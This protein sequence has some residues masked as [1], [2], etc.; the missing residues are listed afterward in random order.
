MRVSNAIAIVLLFLTGYA[1]GR[2]SGAP[3]V[4]DRPR[5]GRAWE[6]AGGDHDGAG[7]I[8]T[9]RSAFALMHCGSWGSAP[10]TPRGQ[11]TDAL[12]A[13]ADQLRCRRPS[14]TKRRASLV[15]L[16][17]GLHLHRARQP[18]VRAAHLHGG[19][20]TGCISKPATTT[21]PST[22]AR[23]GSATTSAAARSWRGSSRRCSAACSATPPASPRATKAR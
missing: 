17:L 22:P 14:R 20:R 8:R 13:P 1:F 4:A 19:S 11:P 18:R 21:K 7:R 16:R 10:R 6:R 9:M 3:P 2:V 5:D 12:N 23:R 15:L